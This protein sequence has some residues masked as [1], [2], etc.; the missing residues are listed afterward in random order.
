MGEELFELEVTAKAVR[1]RQ[2]CQVEVDYCICAQSIDCVQAG[3]DA[4]GESRPK[5]RIAIASDE[6]QL[7]LMSREF[8]E[9]SPGFKLLKTQR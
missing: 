7:P 2:G 8:T 3:A 9:I 4:L 6:H 5:L 1:W